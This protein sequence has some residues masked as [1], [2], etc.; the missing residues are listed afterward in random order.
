MANWQDFVF[1][2]RWQIAALLIGLILAAAGLFLHFYIGSQTDF[3]IVSVEDSNNKSS[4]G[5]NLVV[6]VSGAVNYP[7][8]FEL[9]NGARIED[10]LKKA[11]GLSDSANKNW[12]EKYLNRASLLVD[13]QKIYIPGASNELNNDLNPQ[14]VVS[15]QKTGIVNINTATS[16]ELESLH[17]IGPVYAQKIID[18]RPYSNVNE[19]LVKKVLPQKIYD[20]NK[21]KMTVY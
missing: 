13:G 7:G 6:E 9:P 2:F 8:V 16:K 14:E 1:R 5:S 21:D 10:A 15:S 20:N 4:F 19:L 17:G 18:N 12:V 11:G 3:E